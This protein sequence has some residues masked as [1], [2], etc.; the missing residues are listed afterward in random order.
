MSEA[1]Q[2]WFISFTEEEEAVIEDVL[3][4]EGYEKTPAGLKEFVLDII[5][6]DSETENRERRQ[7]QDETL[8]E[9]ITQFIKENPE[10]I[11]KYTTIGKAAAG[12]ILN[13]MK[14]ARRSA[15]L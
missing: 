9:H 11:N 7:R 1:I 3:F 15:G 5:D 6:E 10:V 14:K 4:E 12:S 2:G 13:A 8:A